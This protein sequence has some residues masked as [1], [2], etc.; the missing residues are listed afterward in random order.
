[1]KLR[2]VNFDVRKYLWFHV[3]YNCLENW[4]FRNNLCDAI[5]Q[6]KNLYWEQ[7]FLFFVS[8]NMEIN[9]F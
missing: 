4:W 2:Y 7:E 9:E 8:D 1:M 3:A 5:F 6:N